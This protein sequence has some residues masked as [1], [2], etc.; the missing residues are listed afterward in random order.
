MR[1]YGKVIA[2]ITTILCFL[3]IVP[4]VQAQ[5]QTQPI[6]NQ[7]VPQEQENATYIP[8]LM[9]HNFWNEQYPLPTKEELGIPGYDPQTAPANLYAGKFEQQMQWLYENGWQT[10]TLDEFYEWVQGKR[11]VPPKSFVITIDDGYK[12]VY[13]VAYPILKKYNYKA[14]VF[15]VTS[16][17]VAP[18]KKANFPHMTAQEMA[19]AS[20]VFTYGSHTHDLHM[21]KNGKSLLF[22][23][24]LSVIKQD[25]EKSRNLLYTEYFAYP[26]GG[27]DGDIENIVREAG[28][29]MAFTTGDRY[30]YVNQDIYAIR[31][32]DITAQMSIDEFITIMEGKAQKNLKPM[33]SPFFFR[34]TTL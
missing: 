1:K 10:I 17:M 13:T 4:L 16:Y 5:E 30:A 31:R 34:V 8:V 25:I 7:Q 6:E 23:T 29:K 28:Y 26:Y 27:Y 18:N 24:P 19:K 9:Y 2:I 3:G 22:Y 20:D 12:S 33:F 11:V 15:V 21:V 32:F 14:T